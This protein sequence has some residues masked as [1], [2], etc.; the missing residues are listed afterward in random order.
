MRLP[1]RSKTESVTGMASGSEK[2]IVVP[3]GEGFGMAWTSKETGGSSDG[4]LLGT[5]K[6]AKPQA[7]NPPARK[8]PPPT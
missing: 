4:G 2:R 1:C 8:N 5:R 3:D 7:G 6:A